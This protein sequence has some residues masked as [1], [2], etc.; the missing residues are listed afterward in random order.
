MFYFFRKKVKHIKTFH[1]QNSLILVLC[2][3]AFRIY[4]FFMEIRKYIQKIQIHLIDTHY[5]ILGYFEENEKVKNYRPQNQGWTISE[6]LEHIALTS[7]FLLILIDK[8]SDKALRNIKNLSLEE[9][10]QKFHYDLSKLNEI[11]IHKSFEWL[12]PEHMEPKSDKTELE[13]KDILILQL[14]RCLS[15]L[16]KL[17]N[18]EGLLYKTTMTV[19]NLGKINVYEYIYFL[20]KHA[21]RHISQIEMNKKEAGL[22]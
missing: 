19:H 11:G 20:S 17:K 2:N 6:V 21:E 10:L 7:H 15:Y 13:L 3:F 16:E 12:R 14:N 22:I 5:K 8:G 4:V 9:E 1:K 18:G